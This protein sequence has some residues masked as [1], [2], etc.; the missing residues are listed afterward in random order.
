VAGSFAS[1]SAAPARDR[2]RSGPFQRFPSAR[3][4]W[5][6]TTLLALIVGACV[7][8]VWL[9]FR[10]NP[11]DQ[12]WSDPARH[13]L[14]GTRPL[15]TSPLSAMDPIGYPIYLG[16]LAKLTAKS[17]P[18]VAY[19]TALLSVCGPWLWYRF[20]RELLPNREWALAGWLLLAALPSWSAIYSY[21][22]QE[23]LMLPLL[24]AALWATWRSR[25]KGDTASFVVAVG[26]WLLAGLTRGICLPLG[27]VAMTWVWIEQGN[28]VQRAL[29]SI[30]LLLTILIPLTGR[31]WSL[32]RLVSPHG[33]GQLAHIY[34]LAGTARLSFDFSRNGGQERWTYEFLSPSFQ[35]APFAPLS[36]WRG[37]RQSVSHFSIDLDAGARD[38]EAAKNSLPPFLADGPRALRLTGENLIFL[39]FGPSWPDTDI[40]GNL[41]RDIGKLNYWMRWIWAP[42]TIV[43]LLTT[44]MN[45]R[46]DRQRN[47]LLPALL[48]VWVIVQ[49]L[50]PLTV[51]EG[52]YRK[53]FEG[54]LIAQTLLLAGGRVRRDGLRRTQATPASILGPS[55][56]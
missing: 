16:I 5:V 48:L 17:R 2:S 55:L 41:H 18:L 32:A 15:D 26:L 36:D 25:R 4:H 44:L 33:I 49:G 28:K 40:E 42:L 31:S 39:F 43:C 54:L 24:G 30:L 6:A 52:R 3:V 56:P 10:F 23:T 22:M 47:R 35:H 19:W 38:W 53:P 8:R 27:A 45:W 11:L 14:E 34:Q 9:V 51:N 21:F 20:L 7:Y 12:L 29:A 46:A 37:S 50:F 1:A 13:W